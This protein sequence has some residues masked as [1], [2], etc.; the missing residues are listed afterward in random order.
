MI[1][2]DFEYYKPETIE[3]ATLLYLELKIQGKKPIYYGGGTEIISMSRSFNRYTE[4]IIDIKGIVEC[5]MFM[6]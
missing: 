4:A 5:I 1:P 6:N 3:E 2:Y